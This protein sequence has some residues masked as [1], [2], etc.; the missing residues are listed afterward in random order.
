MKKFEI[1]R[2]WRNCVFGVILAVL[3]SNAFAGIVYRDV[4]ESYGNCSW[5][6]N[7]D[8]TSTIELVIKFRATN[9]TNLAWQK[10]R[11]RGIVIYTY[12]QYGKM[13]PSSAAAKY[14][15]LNGKKHTYYFTESTYVMYHGYRTAGEIPSDWL[16]PDAFSANIQVMIDNSAIKDW[17][18]IGVRAG[19]FTDG[20][21]VG[22]V[23]GAVYVSKMS[24]AS[25]CTVIDPE[26]PP[27]KPPPAIEIAVAAPD[28]N[29][30]ELPPGDGE[31]TLSGTAQQLCFTY[32][33]VDSYRNFVIDATSKNGVSGDRYLLANSSKPSETVS[34][35]LTLDSGTASF[36]L[37]NKAEKSVKLNKGNRTC[38]VP[39]FRTTVGQGA[40]AG[41]YSDVL[42]FTVVTKS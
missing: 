28:W 32:T 10:F 19:N 20:T 39:T 18:G 17:P 4:I 27:P 42:S 31:K 37:P 12:D 8:G 14:V 30:G 35:D 1:V 40:G 3:S 23:T 36:L 6:N 7:G 9:A 2:H 38:F 26:V 34:Y 41:N 13:R 33:G 25:T 5:K 11:S 21:D 29:L 24:G 16:I 22:E 15:M